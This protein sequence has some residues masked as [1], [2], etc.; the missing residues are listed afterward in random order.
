MKI[1][2]GA[3]SIITPIET[4]TYRVEEEIRKHKYQKGDL[5]VFI[6]TVYILVLFSP[7]SC[8]LDFSLRI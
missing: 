8:F 2:N 1:E 3:T 7:H 6:Y 5:L 4:V